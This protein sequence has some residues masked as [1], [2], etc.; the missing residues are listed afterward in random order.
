MNVKLMGRRVNLVFLLVGFALIVADFT[1]LASTGYWRNEYRETYRGYE[2]WFFPEPN[3]YGIYVGTGDPAGTYVVEDWKHYS[4]L[5]ACKGAIDNWVDNPQYVED[6]HTWQI[7]QESGGTLRYYAVDPETGE[8][9]NFYPSNDLQGLKTWIEE[10]EGVT[11]TQPISWA[12]LLGAILILLA[13][14]L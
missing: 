5:S 10:Q 7:F 6:Y 4:S 12:T 3:V 14:I 2:I 1:L 8:Q 13:F 11:T 9:S